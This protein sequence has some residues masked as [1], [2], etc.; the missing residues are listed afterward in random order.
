MQRDVRTGVGR[1]E[2]RGVKRERGG[3]GTESAGNEQKLREAMKELQEFR[4]KCNLS[5]IRAVNSPREAR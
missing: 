3:G 4:Y 2:E 1:P 5:V